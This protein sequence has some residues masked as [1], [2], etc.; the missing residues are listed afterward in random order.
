MNTKVGSVVSTK[1]RETTRQGESKGKQQLL[2]V[3]NFFLQ[4]S[5]T[6]HSPLYFHHHH[7]YNHTTLFILHTFSWPSSSKTTIGTGREKVV[8]RESRLSDVET[9]AGIGRWKQYTWYITNYICRIKM[10]RWASASRESAKW[11]SKTNS[12]QTNKNI[13]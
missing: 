6:L 12:I 10:N 4:N 13:I 5:T 2:R 9:W 7:H 3:H 1:K 8:L 11:K